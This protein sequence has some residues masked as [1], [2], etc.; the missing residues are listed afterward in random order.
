MGD[1]WIDSGSWT[2]VPAS[3][4]AASCIQE[5]RERRRR[6]F[7]SEDQNRRLNTSGTRVGLRLHVSSAG[8]GE[9]TEGGRNMLT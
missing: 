5:A 6:E 4:G 7:A 3:Q 8:T 9:E 1:A 2:R